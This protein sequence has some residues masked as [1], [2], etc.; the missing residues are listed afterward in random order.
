MP[1]QSERYPMVKII[2][3]R[4][5]ALASRCHDEEF[6]KRF[7]L[8]N[9]LCESWTE[10]DVTTASLAHISEERSCQWTEVDSIM[11]S[12]DAV[13]V[14]DNDTL[15]TVTGSASQQPQS[16]SIICCHCCHSL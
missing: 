14:A 15:I 7:N 12:G 8:L 9:V 3:D 6:E 1:V 5:A 2:C 11:S 16:Q 4:L 13:C 10:A